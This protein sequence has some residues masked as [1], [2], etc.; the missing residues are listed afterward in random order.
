[1]LGRVV[2]FLSSTTLFYGSLYYVAGDVE[3]LEF[4]IHGGRHLYD[5]D[6]PL[7]TAIRKVA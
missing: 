5:V 1:M 7:E 2:R 6:I 4:E 3:C